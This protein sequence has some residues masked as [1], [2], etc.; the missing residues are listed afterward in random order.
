M[1]GPL[2]GPRHSPWPWG[3]GIGLGIVVAVNAFMIHI[4]LSHP[5]VPASQDHYGESLHWDEVQA[6]RGRAAALGWQVELQPCASLGPDGCPLSLH[7]RDAQGAA[8]AGLHGEIRAERA[9]DP[10]L[11]R[12]AAVTA[13]AEAGAYQGHLALGRPGL[14]TLS[15]RLEGGPA[16][17]VDTRRIRVLGPAGTE[18]EAP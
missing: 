4:A 5:S 14:Y 15:M 7:V 10:T 1:K 13:G 9:D 2:K 11:D 12:T 18:A 6:E 8:V 17:W 16:P 3:I